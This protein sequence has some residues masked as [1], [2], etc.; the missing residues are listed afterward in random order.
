MLALLGSGALGYYTADLRKPA[1]CDLLGSYE[2]IQEHIRYVG[3]VE[4]IVANY[5]ADSGRKIIVKTTEHIREYEVCWE[6]SDSE[7]LLKLIVADEKSFLSDWDHGNLIVPDLDVLY[8]LK[9]SHRYRKDSPHF[10]KTLDDILLMRKLGA[11]IRPAHEEWLKWRERETYT[12][13]LPKLN[14]SRKDFF[15]NSN[16]IYTLNHDCIHEAVKHLDRPA[17]EYYKPDAAEVM[18]SKEMFFACSEEVRLYGAIEEVMVLSLERSIYPFPNVDRKWAFDMAHM[19]LAS[20]ISSG[21]F[22][23]FVWENYYK[24]QAMYSEDYV[25]KFYEALHNGKI[26]SFEEMK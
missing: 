2:E 24:V 18:T 26:K 15:D 20:S 23:E 14:Q 8:A 13:A 16:S 25:D 5:P 10:K 12:N 22:R 21:W 19:K 11:K 17:Y 3:K 7:A 1:D 9:M 4:K 6:G